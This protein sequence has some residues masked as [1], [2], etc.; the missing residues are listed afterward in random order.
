MLLN[1]LIWSLTLTNKTCITLLSFKHINLDENYLNAICH[2]HSVFHWTK[3]SYV[4][5]FA[6]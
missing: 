5:Y 6:Q 1:I 3:E 2:Q 4:M